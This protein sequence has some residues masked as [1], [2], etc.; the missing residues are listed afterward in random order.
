[1]SRWKA[2]SQGRSRNFRRRRSRDGDELV[3]AGTGP[4]VDAGGAAPSGI[5]FRVP[6]V[7]VIVVAT[8][9]PI[10]RLVVIGKADA[11]EPLGALPKVEVRDHGSHGSAVGAGQGG[12]VQ[13][14]S[15]QHRGLQRVTE[16][17]VGRVAV[18][19]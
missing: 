16:R 12:A 7:G 15:D 2:R 9:L 4:E 3:G 11:G 18:R 14:M 5:A 19:G 8:S 17:D 1:M 13:L 6:G 10:A